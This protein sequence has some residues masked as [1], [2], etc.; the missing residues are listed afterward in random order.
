M[1]WIMESNRQWHFLGAAAL[2]TL[3]TFFCGLGVA[4]GME[5]K[6]V[7]YNNPGSNPWNYKNWSSWDWLDFL[8]TVL[9]ALVG[10]IIQLLLI[11]II[12]LI[13]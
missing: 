2:S 3:F 8:A 10:Q 9:G 11:W 7:Q 13:F 4:I 12:I 1:S 6:D 5:F